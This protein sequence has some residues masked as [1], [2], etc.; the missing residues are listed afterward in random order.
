MANAADGY[1]WNADNAFDNWDLNPL[2]QKVGAGADGVRD[3]LAAG[4]DAYLQPQMQQYR[5]AATAAGARVD[6]GDENLWKSEGFRD[7]AKT[8][9]TSFAPQ[10][11]TPSQQWTAQPGGPGGLPVTGTPGGAQTPNTLVNPLFDLLMQRIQQPITP[12]AN[13]PTIR[14]QA[15]AYSAQQ[16]RNSRNYL[17]D[18]AERGGPYSNLQG[19]ARLASEHAGQLSGQFEAGLIGQEQNARRASQQHDLDQYGSQLSDQQRLQL[20]E[21]LGLRSAAAQDQSINNQ[22]SLGLLGN[23]TT[24][25]GQNMSYDQFLRELALRESNQNNQ[26]DYNWASL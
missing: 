15:D 1:Q 14:R 6:E 21:E 12:D 24:Q 11:Q 16:T 19:E 18:Q 9:Q 20:Q 8:G 13:D 7:F 3:T 2:A 5:N 4:R 17:A 22:Y 23:Q 25:R 26:W 10:N